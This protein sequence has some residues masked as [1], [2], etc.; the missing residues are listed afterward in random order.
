MQPSH[1]ISNKIHPAAQATNS[2]FLPLLHAPQP[3]FNPI[4]L[5]LPLKHTPRLPTCL[6]C[7]PL[8]ARLPANNPI[9]PEKSEYCFH[10][11]GT[12]AQKSLGVPTALQTTRGPAFLSDVIFF[13]WRPCSPGTGKTGHLSGLRIPRTS[14]CGEP[15]TGSC[16]G[17]RGAPSGS[18]NTW[19]ACIIQ[20]STH[21]KQHPRHLIHTTLRSNFACVFVYLPPVCLPHLDINPRKAGTLRVVFIVCPQHLEQTTAQCRLVQFTRRRPVLSFVARGSQAAPADAQSGLRQPR[22][23]RPSPWRWSP[24]TT[25]D[26]K[27]RSETG[28]AARLT[29]SIWFL[30]ASSGGRPALG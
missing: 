3:V 1:L 22:L 16:I 29:G 7:Y 11:I 25:E 12:P 6:H 15:G 4:P 2:C 19:L 26:V 5:A 23:P 28:R 8:P 13:H 10:N 17:P 30:G 24:S 14:S 9:C 27:L 20:L 18:V 21:L